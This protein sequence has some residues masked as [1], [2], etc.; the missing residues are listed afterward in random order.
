MNIKYNW[1][2]MFK[3]NNEFVINEGSKIFLE[4]VLINM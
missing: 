1:I 2:N 4:I 3:I